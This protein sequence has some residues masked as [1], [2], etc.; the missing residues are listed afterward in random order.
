MLVL[1]PHSFHRMKQLLGKGRSRV[2]DFNSVTWLKSQV[3]MLLRHGP[4]L[5]SSWRPRSSI[6]PGAWDVTGLKSSELTTAESSRTDVSPP[7]HC[8]R[9]SLALRA[10]PRQDRKE[11]DPQHTGQSLVCS[12]NRPP[13]THRHGLPRPPI[14]LTAS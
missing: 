12:C 8:S 4:P 11:G 7:Q 1:P 6:S 10:P 13:S 2:L 3:L 5:V 9:S 14:S